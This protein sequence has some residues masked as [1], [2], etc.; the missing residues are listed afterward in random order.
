MTE[1]AAAQPAG[2]LSAEPGTR[3]SGTRGDRTR[4]LIKKAIA[5][6][7][8]RRDVADITLSDICK[9][10]KL[11]TGA[12]Y[13]HFKSKDEA[14]EEMIIDEVSDRYQMVINSFRGGGFEAL[15]ASTIEQYT[16]FHRRRGQ[17]PRAIQAIINARPTA[18]QAWLDSRRPLILMFQQA[19]AEARAARGLPTHDAPYLAHFILNSIEDLAMDVFQWKNPTLTPFADTEENW[20][21]RQAA[22]WAW[23]VLAPMPTA[24]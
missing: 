23:A 22:L 19:I 3:E 8:S 20:N 5:R 24:V 16:K 14:V 13:F 2:A 18:Y 6:L 4:Q 12:L 17:L 15:V 7:A 1:I 21:R 9:A 10:T 11:T